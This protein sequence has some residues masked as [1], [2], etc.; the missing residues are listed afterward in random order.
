MASPDAPYYYGMPIQARRMIFIIDTSGSMNGP[1]LQAA[2]RELSQAIYDLPNNASF[3]I[4]TF[5]DKAAAWRPAMT[6]TTSDAKQA[7]GKF[8]YNLYAGGH[9]AAYDALDMS[10]RFDAEAVYFLSDGAPNAGKIPAPKA[11]I[12]TVTQTNRSR[13]IT[14]N[15]IGISPGPPD[16]PLDAFVKTLAE[17]NFGVYRRVEE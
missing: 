12:D 8:I 15:T 9:T 10:F 4:I 16:G 17:Q 6:P 7:A 3:N 2:K 13:R 11:I 5:N 1:R 14:I